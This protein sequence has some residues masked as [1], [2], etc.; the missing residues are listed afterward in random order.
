MHSTLTV[1]HGD[2]ERDVVSETLGCIEAYL[3]N[4]ERVNWPLVVQ[5]AAA[6]LLLKRRKKWRRQWVRQVLQNRDVY[7]EFHHLVQELRLYDE[8]THFGYFRMTKERFDQLL[9][10]IGPLIQRS[11]TSFRKAIPAAEKLSLTLRRD[12]F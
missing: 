2:G 4:T 6:A 3:R 1:K 8:K 11:D 7:G 12:V 9:T 5:I 10:L